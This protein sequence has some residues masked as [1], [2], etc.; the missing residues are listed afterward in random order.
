MVCSGAADIFRRRDGVLLEWLKR[1]GNAQSMVVLLRPYARQVQEAGSK[2]DE[3]DGL[4][5]LRNHKT[6]TCSVH[7]DLLSGSEPRPS[8]SPRNRG[9]CC[10]HEEAPQEISHQPHTWRGEG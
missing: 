1:R 5:K 6:M 3:L 8:V 10:R 2:K 7:V 9:P 4:D